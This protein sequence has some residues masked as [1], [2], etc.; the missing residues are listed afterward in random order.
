MV[1]TLQLATVLALGVR[2]AGQSLVAAPH[3]RSGR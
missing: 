2:L 1:R 3:A